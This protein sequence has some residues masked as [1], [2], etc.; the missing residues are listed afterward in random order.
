[1]AA[2][3]IYVPFLFYCSLVKI[4]E[5]NFYPYREQAVKIIYFKY[6]AESIKLSILFDKYFVGSLYTTSFY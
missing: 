6:H 1:M 3:Q 5:Q 2:L 4:T